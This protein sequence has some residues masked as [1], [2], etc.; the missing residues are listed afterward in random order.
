MKFSKPKYYKTLVNLFPTG[1]DRKPSMVGLQRGRSA[2][3]LV[4][5]HS[6]LLRRVNRLNT[7]AFGLA[8]EYLSTWS[9]VDPGT[10]KKLDSFGQR[11]VISVERDE[12]GHGAPMAFA[13]SFYLSRYVYMEYSGTSFPSRIVGPS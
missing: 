6:A 4:T 11:R 7:S 8:D 12:K 5:R 1:G 13:D 3:P 10:V 2:L 9:G